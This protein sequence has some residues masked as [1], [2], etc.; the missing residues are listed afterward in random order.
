VRDERLMPLTLSSADIWRRLCGISR[1]VCCGGR[2]G[3]VI[4]GQTGLLVGRISTTDLLAAVGKLVANRAM[5]D[6][7]GEHGRARV[8]QRFTLIHQ[9]NAWVDCFKRLCYPPPEIVGLRSLG[10]AC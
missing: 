1:R 3:V 9:A 7:L 2:N 10:S 6:K 8:E 4:D 5:R